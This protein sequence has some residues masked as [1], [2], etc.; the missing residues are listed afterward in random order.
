MS[1][2]IVL[3]DRPTLVFARNAVR[4]IAWTLHFKTAQLLIPVKMFLSVPYHSTNWFF[5][6]RV[7]HGFRRGT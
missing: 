3:A 2:R 4:W 1:I 5:V 7:Q 6:S